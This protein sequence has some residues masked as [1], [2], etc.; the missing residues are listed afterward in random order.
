MKTDPSANRRHKIHLILS[1]S[2]VL[3]AMPATADVR[4]PKIFTDDM[5]LQRDLP[6][7]V[8]GWADADEAVSVTLAG[9]SA[10][11]KPDAQGQWALELPALKTGEKLE[12]TV[13]AKTF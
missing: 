6:V 3:T 5:M 13:R 12:M 8:W 7:R 1:A 11:A 9:K 2:I 10:K 4:L